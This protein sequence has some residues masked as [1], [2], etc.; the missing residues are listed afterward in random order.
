[1][2]RDGENSLKEKLASWESLTFL[3]NEMPCAIVSAPVLMYVRGCI[4]REQRN[5]AGPDDILIPM[6]LICNAGMLP[7]P[8]ILSRNMDLGLGCIILEQQRAD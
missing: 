6:G 1:M 5:R 4:M 3:D 2:H 8:T 7:A